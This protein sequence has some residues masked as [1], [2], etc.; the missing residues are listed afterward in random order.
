MKF[1]ETHYEEYIHSIEQYNIHPEMLAIYKHFP[2]TLSQFGNIIVYGPPGSGKYSQML[3]FLKKYSPSELKYDK[4]IVCQTDK[5]NYSYHISDIHYEIDMSTLGCNSKL[6][7]HE[8]FLQI[9]D[10]ISVKTEK[11]GIIVCKNFHM[12]H[13]ELLDIF[14]SY[15]Q[16]YHSTNIQIKFII[17]SEHISFIPKNIL[18]SFKIISVKRPD[19]IHYI[20][21]INDA[22]DKTKLT[23]TTTNTFIHRIN[24]TI[25]KPNRNNT[26]NVEESANKSSNAKVCKSTKKVEGIDTENLNNSESKNKMKHIM[27]CLEPEYIINIKETESFSLMNDGSEIP[28]DN[29]N[30]ICNN[31][32]QEIL[33]YKKM[34]FTHFRDTIYDIL[35]YN[36]DVPECVW[37][38]LSYFIQ[39][40]I[41]TESEIENIL[42]KIFVFLKYY[43]NNY[44]PIYH[45]ESIFFYII[46]IIQNK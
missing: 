35:V 1:Y 14:Y 39:R 23:D 41:F 9:I 25:S 3:Y 32:I 24:P 13:T 42:D 7:W 29:F 21:R 43:N 31:I 4:K 11:I 5:V 2:K 34:V 22:C 18:E 37:Y 27:D 8:L 16:N 26:N 38:V 15:I 10:I 20:N 36:L 28:K 6:L 44:R 40:N 45:L 17:I 19:K 46:T 30:T 12:I 33:Q